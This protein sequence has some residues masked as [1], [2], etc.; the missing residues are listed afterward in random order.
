MLNIALL[1]STPIF[2]RVSLSCSKS[3]SSNAPLTP[4]SFLY[5]IKLNENENSSIPKMKLRFKK[6]KIFTSIKE[7]II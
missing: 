3:I 5:G 4:G 1:D 6:Y 7:I 2:I